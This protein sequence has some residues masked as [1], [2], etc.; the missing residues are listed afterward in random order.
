VNCQLPSTGGSGIALLAFASALVVIGLTL[1][2]AMRGH[3][4]RTAPVA[5][6]IVALTVCALAVERP[7]EAAF[8][9]P[10]TTVPTTL[11][12]STTAAALVPTSAPSTTTAPTTTIATT[13]TLG[14]V[15]FCSP[16]IPNDSGGFMVDV[17]IQLSGGIG[18][19]SAR[20]PSSGACDG[21][22]VNSGLVVDS[23][24]VA[25]PAEYCAT[26][27]PGSQ[28]IQVGAAGAWTV[29]PP[30]TWFACNPMPPPE[31]TTTT[32]TTATVPSVPPA[33]VNDVFDLVIGQTVG[34]N[35]LTNDQL[36]TP[37]ASLNELFDA[38]GTLPF[39]G[40]NLFVT[41]N[42]GVVAAAVFVSVDGTITIEGASAGSGFFS[43]SLVQPGNPT[44]ALGTVFVNVS[45]PP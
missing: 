7:A 42:P 15:N 21:E 14:A 19:F 18:T 6:A 17:L 40:F 27:L 20:A 9:C 31:T 38:N 11:A 4:R 36:G 30:S 3:R 26:N 25:D 24:V 5:V 35:I 22:V 43:Y 37:T 34:G 2:A 10:P 28:L 33:T 45:A 23:N 41:G 32:T 12:T 1:V 8:D 16:L 29:T 44:P 39:G 13:T